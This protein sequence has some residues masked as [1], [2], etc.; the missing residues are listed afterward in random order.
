MAR[1]RGEAGSGRPRGDLGGVGGRLVPAEPHL[2]GDG[3]LRRR[4][5]GL[6]D[7]EREVGLA[8]QRGAGEAACHLLGGTAEIDVDDAR[9]GALRKA[10][11]FRHPGRVAARELDDVGENPLPFR[12]QPRFFLS[13]HEPLRGHHLGNDEIRAEPDRDTPEGDVGDA[14]HRGEH[15]GNASLGRGMTA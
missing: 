3:H 11:R 10:R 5:D 14:R 8:H 2:H 9:P 6:D 12:A 1:P 13:P 4:D 7:A 15:H